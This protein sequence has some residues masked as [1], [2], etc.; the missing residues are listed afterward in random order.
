MRIATVLALALSLLL[1]AQAASGRDLNQDEAL[2]LKRAGRIMPLEQ[3]LEEVRKYYPDAQLLEVELE[4]EHHIYVYEIDL[5]TNK[6]E[7][8]E[9]ELDAQSGRLLKDEED[10]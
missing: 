2:K 4:E 1:G 7:A 9:L 6:G 3:V 10:D 5:L 8:R